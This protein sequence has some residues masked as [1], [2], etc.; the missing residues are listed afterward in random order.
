V[1]RATL[2][3]LRTTGRAADAIARVEA[4][5]RRN[6]LWF[7]PQA[8]PR[9]TRTVTIDL[10]QVGTHVAGPRRPQDLHGL[11]E[12]R[13]VLEAV[14]FRP[15]GE[16]AGLPK[17]PVA[18]AA[19]TS[20]TNTTDPG[21]LVAAGL[22]ARKARRLGLRVPAWVKT[23]L[24]P[25]SPAAA[26]YL[27]RAGLLED[28]GAVG[29]DIVGFGCTTCI[30]NSGALGA[31]VADAQRLGAAQ[32]VAILSGNR[33]FPGRVHPDLEL[34]FIL[35][36]PLVIAFALAGDAQ[37]NLRAEPLQRAPDGR[38][39]YLRDLWPSSQEIDACLREA[40]QAQDFGRDFAAASRNPLWEALEAPASALFPWDEAS[41]QLRR[42]PFAAVTE[43]SML[44]RYTAWPLLSLGNDVTTDHISPASAIPPD[45]LVADHLVA[46]GERRDDLNVFASRRGNWEVMLRGAFHHKTLRNALA[47][48]APVAHTLHVPSGQVV[49]IWEAAQRYRDAG[50]SVVLVA[51]ER[52]GMGSSRDWAAKGQRLLGIRAVLAVSFERIHR[53]N[54]I[55][56]GILPLHLPAGVDPAT[57]ALAPGDRIEIDA[58]AKAVGPRAAI[59]VRVLRSGGTQHAFE[60]RAAV[61]TQLEAELLRYGGVIPAILRKNQC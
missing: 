40:L 47:P 49:P 29:F 56:M 41:T 19:I 21:L 14:G 39:V 58:P 54:L 38:D 6:A 9:Y 26:S 48:G 4:Y 24:A 10:A 42:P 53:S 17:H 51:G 8:E 44:G 36:P 3:Y 43:G 35:S 45:S 28:L 31:A 23:S 22:L 11:A 18:I 20:C 25:G 50:E 12:T 37:R 57:L 46:R 32:G 59:A 33:N 2:D 61:E 34:S 1:D 55:G 7:D 60:A 5:C 30:G 16:V 27:R 13:E 15:T 52:Y